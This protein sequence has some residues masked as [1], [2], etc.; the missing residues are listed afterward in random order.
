[1][2]MD[3][4]TG[5]VIDEIEDVTTT[6]THTDT[7]TNTHTHTRIGACADDGVPGRCVFTSNQVIHCC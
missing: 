7:N 2:V 4:D 1:M 6:L 3:E 5:N